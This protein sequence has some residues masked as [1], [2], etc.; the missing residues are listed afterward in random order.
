MDGADGELGLATAS[1]TPLTG[2]GVWQQFQ[3]GRIY[4]SQATGAHAIKG[5]IGDTYVALG[6]AALTKLGLPTYDEVKLPDGWYQQF[7]NAGIYWTNDGGKVVT[8]DVAAK[9]A[10]LGKTTSATAT[11]SS[12][13]SATASTSTATTATS[14]NSAA[15]ATTKTSSN[16]SAANTASAKSTAQ[17][18]T[19]ATSAS[20]P[21]TPTPANSSSS[22]SASPATPSAAAPSTT[23]SPTAQAPTTQAPTSAIADAVAPSAQ[24]ATSGAIGDL[25]NQLGGANGVLGAATSSETALSGGGARQQFANGRIYWSQAT[26]AHAIKGGI[27]DVYFAMGDS[28]L[29]DIGLPTGDERDLGNGMWVQQFQN[30]RIFWSGATGGHATNGDIA[31]AYAALGDSAYSY[32]GLPTADPVSVRSGVMQSFQ[33]GRIFWSPTTGAHIVHGGINDTYTS[34]GSSA[35]ADLGLPTSD[36]AAVANGWAQ[37]FEKG[38]IF[39][40]YATAGVVVHGNIGAIYASLGTDGPASLGLPSG[41]VTTLAD[42]SQHQQFQRG[43][44]YWS[45][46]SGARIVHN[47]IGDTFAAMASAPSAMGMPTGD[48]VDLGNGAWMQQFQNGRIYWS[49]ATGGHAIKGGI[50]DTFAAMGDSAY[51]VLGLPTSDEIV[52]ANGWFQHFQGGGMFWS[53]P[54]GG[55]LVKGAIGEAFAAMGDS[56]LSALGTPTSNEMDLGNG[57]WMQQFQ[58]GRI[59]WS[60]AAGGHAIKGGIGDTFTAMGNSAYG[61]L[62]LPTS[63]EITLPNG[64]YQQFQGGRIYWSGPTGGHMVRGGIGDSYINQG[65]STG[66]LGLPTSSEISADGGSYQVFQGGRIY[67]KDGLG[68]A[69]VRGA[70]LDEYLKLGASS[71]LLQF[72]RAGEAA[73]N[74]GVSQDFEGGRIYWRPNNYAYAVRGAVGATYFAWGASDG[75]LGF[76]TSDEAPTDDGTIQTF[77]NGTIAWKNSGGTVVNVVKGGIGDTFTAMGNS[78]YG[79]LGLPTSNE[80]TLPNG[81]YQQFQGGRIY[82]SGPTGGHMVRGGIGDSYINQGASTGLLG[83]PTSS[84][85][86]ADGGSYQVFQGGR[87]YWKDGLGNA[88]VRG[89]ML[90]EY[91]KLGASSGLLQFPRAGEAAINGG[92]SQ[93]FEGGR[94]Y[95]RPNNYAYAVRGAV[96]ATYFAWGASDGALGFPTSDE[97]PTD[98]GTIQTFQNGTIAWKN[99]GGT[100]VNVV[101]TGGSKPAAGDEAGYIRWVAGFAQEEQRRYRVPA[102]VSI[103]QSIIESGWGQSSLTAVDNNYFGIKCPAYGSPFVSGCTSYST[104]EWVNGG[105]VTIQAGFRSYNSPGDSFLDHGF[106]LSLGDP[107]NSA[108]RYYPAF[109]TTNDR[110]FVRAIAAAG[111]ATDPTYANKIISI[112][113]RYNL[114]QYDV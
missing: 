101:N 15:D 94:I 109:L 23:Q 114:Y 59:F 83:L 49:G 55:V 5:G 30:G 13:P 71:G 69:T 45:Q 75:A 67:W 18:T 73:I 1:E 33:S 51:G 102:A 21:A 89:A 96:G 46:A 19:A 95:W 17:P 26:G 35:F 98:D 86:S 90:D 3:H 28:A 54:T 84:E 79:L 105:Y 72:P 63:N 66:L 31:A 20:T 29:T 85:I 43:L 22:S 80:I 42:G 48:E 70:M 108:N 88:T 8:G 4:W 32:L 91:L 78:A 100:V 62:G 36:E 27:G 65:A 2:G 61:L 25:Y 110:D 76:P 11:A 38:S 57:A 56:A 40:S 97:A 37:Q 50:G 77:Q 60:G 64:W 12:A 41:Q 92:V 68:N 47:G 24:I 112:M 87:I 39:W 6:D 74:G 113:D 111:Y 93:D 16:S 82:W 81:W 52:L 14:A 9:Y 34:L 104:S 44:I 7:Q 107:S 53:G 10:A 106:F 99:S 58:N 103:A